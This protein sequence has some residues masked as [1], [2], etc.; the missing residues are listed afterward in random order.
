L[1]ARERLIEV[2]NDN[3]DMVQHGVDVPRHGLL[4]TGH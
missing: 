3:R 2:G 4:G 1:V